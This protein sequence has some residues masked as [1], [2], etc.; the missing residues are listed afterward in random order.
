[1]TPALSVLNK[2]TFHDS[3]PNI[4]AKIKAQTEAVENALRALPPLP[5]RN[6]QHVVRDRLQR[7]SNGVQRLLEGGAA[8]NGFLSAWSQLSIDF[9]DAIQTMRPMFSYHHPSDMELPE[10][11]EIDDDTD[12]ESVILNPTTPQNRNKRPGDPFDTP[13]PAKAQKVTHTSRDSSTTRAPKQEGSH[14]GSPTPQRRQ[15]QLQQ[16]K[17]PP[18][19]TVFDPYLGL[20]KSFMT[21]G[22]VR[23]IIAK[24]KRPGLPDH[25]DDAAK[26]DICLTSVNPWNLPLEALANQTFKMLREA[27]L[28]MLNDCL[29]DYK[30]TELYRASKRHILE[31]LEMHAIDQRERLDAFYKVE[32]YKL[33]TINNSAFE[34]Y[35]AQELKLLQDARRKRRVQCYVRKQAQLARKVYSD[36]S[37]AAAEKAVTDAQLGPD[38]FESE[39]QL[40]AYVRGYYKTAGLRFADNLCQNIQGNLFQKIHSEIL[41]LLEGCLNLNE[42]DGKFLSSQ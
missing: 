13:N 21:I 2:L 19:Q 33:F 18:R 12:T 42:G 16:M 11:I 23:T 26:G 5:R 29:G 15:P 36:T 32:T 1:M 34:L 41:G 35:K 4:N 39:I 10:V 38:P 9:R 37:R 30:Q 24:H 3:M 8:S 40:A 20:G 14:A 28:S 17:P 25:V 6:I 22:E 27:V 7:F 31:F